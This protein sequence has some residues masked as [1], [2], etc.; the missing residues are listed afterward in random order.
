MDYLHVKHLSKK[1]VVLG[2]HVHLYLYDDEFAYTVD[3]IVDKLPTASLNEKPKEQDKEE[4]DLTLTIHDLF[5]SSWLKISDKDE[6]VELAP[7]DIADTVSF[8]HDDYIFHTL[9]MRMY[10]APSSFEKTRNKIAIRDNENGTFSYQMNDSWI[11]TWHVT[12]TPIM[13]DMRPLNQQREP[14]FF[15]PAGARSWGKV[16][17]KEKEKKSSKLEKIVNNFFNPKDVVQ[18]GGGKRNRRNPT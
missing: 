1:D 18:K 6:M 14:I 10:K 13:F 15:A 12:Q 2:V 7:N 17:F 5:T 3:H 11:Q 4:Q 8:S 16:E 9:I